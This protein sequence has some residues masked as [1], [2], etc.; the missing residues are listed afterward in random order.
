MFKHAN[1]FFPGDN[2][3]RTAHGAKVAGAGAQ[4]TVVGADPDSGK[5]KVAFNDGSTEYVD[6][7]ELTKAS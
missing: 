1:T 5:V 2:V 3:H 6:P 4:G 7:A